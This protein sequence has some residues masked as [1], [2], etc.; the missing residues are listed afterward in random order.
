LARLR[1]TFG[2]VKEMEKNQCGKKPPKYLFLK[3]LVLWVGMLYT[4][5]MEVEP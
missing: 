3:M 1:A 5:I 4:E 2:V